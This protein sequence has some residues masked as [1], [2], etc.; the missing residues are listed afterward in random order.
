MPEKYS[1]IISKIRNKLVYLQIKT[2]QKEQTR[3]N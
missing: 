3:V 1:I 2:T